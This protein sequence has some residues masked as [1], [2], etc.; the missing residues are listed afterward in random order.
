[1]DDMGA[2]REE[3]RQLIRSKLTAGMTPDQATEAIVK[4]FYTVAD[5]W[6]SVDISTVADGPGRRQLD[7]RWLVGR[8]PRN[9]VERVRVADR[10]V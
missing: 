3:L 4:L 6:D 7:Q 9:S 1:M 5:D 8:I 10:N 2:E